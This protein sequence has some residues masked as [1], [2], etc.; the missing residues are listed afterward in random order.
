MK[1]AEKLNKDYIKASETIS[2]VRYLQL[3]DFLTNAAGRGLPFT[4]ITDGVELA[5]QHGIMFAVV[6][7]DMIIKLKDEGLS[8]ELDTNL[9]HSIAPNKRIWKVEWSK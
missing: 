3:I 5:G 4:H 6:T 9:I 8:V 7:D 1:L 2:N